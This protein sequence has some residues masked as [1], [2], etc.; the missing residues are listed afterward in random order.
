MLVNDGIRRSS[1]VTAKTSGMLVSEITN[2]TSPPSATARLCA[3]T[4]MFGPVESHNWVWVMSTTIVACPCRD[5]ISSAARSTSALV[6]SIS[7]GSATT[8]TLP[9]IS[10][11]CLT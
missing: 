1:P 6:P 9:T 11:K 10:I 4:S 5:A 7:A 8:G 2:R 3:R